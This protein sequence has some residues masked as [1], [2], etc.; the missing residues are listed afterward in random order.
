M[1]IEILTVTERN[2]VISRGIVLNPMTS[3]QVILE[4][5]SGKSF[6]DACLGKVPKGS[7]PIFEPELVLPDGTTVSVDRYCEKRGIDPLS[8]LAHY[9]VG[10]DQPKFTFPGRFHKVVSAGGNDFNLALTSY[11]NGSGMS[12]GGVNVYAALV[13]SLW[14]K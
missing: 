7:L 9:K 1:G 3:R 4:G 5:A 2:E 8:F 12:I 11:I 14:R 13:F 6:I 10:G